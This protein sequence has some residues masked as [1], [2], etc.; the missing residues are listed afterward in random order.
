[1]N[2]GIIFD[3]D[4]VIVS[5]DEN[6]FL[7]W[8]KMA[9]EEGIPFDREVNEFLRGV[10]RMESLAI[11]LKKASKEYTDE[12]KKEMSERKNNYYRESL[13]QITPDDILP[14]VKD[15]LDE[16][17]KRM[18]GKNLGDFEKNP[19]VQNISTILTVAD[20]CTLVENKLA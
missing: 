18:P 10:S 3:L 8:K 5:T 13:M 17:K 4:G 12:Q 2:I 1:M 20:M 15:M 11:V 9:D 19:M 7:A 6:H 16:L 14:G